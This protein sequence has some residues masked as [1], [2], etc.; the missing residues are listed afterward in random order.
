MKKAIS[1]RKVQ[2]MRNL[3][4]KKFNDKTAIMQGY[5]KIN[6]SYGEGDVWEER[7]KTWTIKNGIKQNI[8][9]LQVVRDAVLMPICCPQCS[10][11]MK[12]RLDKKFWKTH[13]KC[14]DCVVDDEH[15]M[16]INQEWSAYQENEIRANVDSFISDLKIRVVEYLDNIENQ[17][18]ITEAGD[19]ETWQGG[20]SKEY[21]KESFNKQIDEFEKKWEKNGSTD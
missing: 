2:R 3:V 16:R 11:V 9:K 17:H 7:G 5:K 10:M 18:F 4:T 12:K 20:Y 14:F 6:E 8:P 21:L 1:E 13:K 19:T 15:T